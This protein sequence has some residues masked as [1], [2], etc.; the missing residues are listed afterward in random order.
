MGDQ[1]N[2]INNLNKPNLVDLALLQ[3]INE[4]YQYSPPKISYLYSLIQ[5]AGSATCSLARDNLFIT[6]VICSLFLFLAWC[7]IEKQR[8]DAIYEKY[9]QKKLVKSLLKDE[10]SLFT[11]T[12]ETINIEKLFNEITTDIGNSVT[13]P[14][15]KSEPE[16]Q[17]ELK[18]EPEPKSEPKSEP[19]QQEPRQF[20]NYIQQSQIHLTKREQNQQINDA[21]RTIPNI[22]N[23]TNV[24]YGGNTSSRYMDLG[25]FNANSYMLL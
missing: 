15:L 25:N 6:L 3:K 1:F 11:E 20:N 18:S 17:S 22:Q 9:L 13:Q 24:I 14:E 5:S 21:N 16:P 7:F 12:P 2:Y 23:H 19:E 8:Q 4:G 10:L